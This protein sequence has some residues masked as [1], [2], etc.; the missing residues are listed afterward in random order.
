ML[1]LLGP[2]TRRYYN[3]FFQC[4]R[5]RQVYRPGSH[6][7]HILEKMKAAGLVTDII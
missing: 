4:P 1:P 5:Y 7:D 3:D 2:K 6:R